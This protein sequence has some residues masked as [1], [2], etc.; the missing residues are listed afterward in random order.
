MRNLKRVLHILK[1]L[2]AQMD[3]IETLS[4]VS[5]RAFRD[6]LENS[7]GFQSVQFREIEYAG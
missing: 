1:V 7:S 6:R 5:F 2:V 4:P 3:I